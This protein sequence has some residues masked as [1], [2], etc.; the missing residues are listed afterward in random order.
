MAGDEDEPQEIVFNVLVHG[1]LDFLGGS[2][3]LRLKIATDLL[4]LALEA[5]VAAKKVD[6]AMLG[7]GHEPGAG[8]VR[9]SRFG[10]ALQR[11]DERVLREIFGN[12]NI[13][14]DA[15]EAGDQSGG[16][17]PPDCV[18]SAMRIRQGHGSGAGF[19][20]ALRLEN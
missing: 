19:G 3:L 2:F 16:F 5:L 10:P 20:F 6:G 1:S 15:R 12:A 17:Y 13:A 11:G 7:G 9:H 4:V 18:N 14:D 8:I